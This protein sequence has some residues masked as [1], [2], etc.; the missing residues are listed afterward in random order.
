MA[1]VPVPVPEVTQVN[2]YE[3]ELLAQAE[4]ASGMEA[5]GGSGFISCQGGRLKVDGEEV[6]GNK[7][8][9][10]II[11]HLLENHYYT[12]RF[13]PDKL[14]SPVCFAFGTEEALLAPH[15]DSPQPQHPTCK[16]CPMNQFGTSDMGAG[17]ACKNSRR[18]GLITEDAA[19][20]DVAGAELRTL[21]LPVT[22]VKNWKAYVQ[23]IA[24]T[25]KRPPLGVVTEVSVVPFKSYFK[26]QFK[27][28]STIADGDTIQALLTRRPIVAEE[29]ARPYQA[30]SADAAQSAPGPLK[31]NR[32]VRR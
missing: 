26:F 2:S 16:G 15:P 17:K 30:P 9:V 7:M 27:L 12:E 13:D 4:V 20:E 31:G 25:M 23:Q 6:P 1:K 8:N 28:V 18:L 11:D 21:K 32:Q 5:G 10:V 14:A 19:E 3:A 29:L 24:S 22:S